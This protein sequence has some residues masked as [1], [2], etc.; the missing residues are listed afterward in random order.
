M[1]AHEV[2]LGW[3]DTIKL[4][5]PLDLKEA[6][7]EQPSWDITVRRQG[8]KEC[9]VYR[10]KR[11]ISNFAADA[12]RGRGTRV[13]E[14]VQLDEKQNEIDEV[15]VLKDSWIDADRLREGDILHKIHNSHPDNLFRWG[16]L[17][18]YPTR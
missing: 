11:V 3:D 10:T 4:T 9:T 15:L 1:S 17:S 7:S 12:I 13:W 18:D 6:N 16:L 2:E 5:K 8:T 14:V